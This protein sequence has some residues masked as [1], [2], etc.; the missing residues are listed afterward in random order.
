MT[1]HEL[2]EEKIAELHDKYGAGAFIGWANLTGKTKQ[3]QIGMTRAAYDLGK[4]ASTAHLGTGWTNDE[5]RAAIN[6]DNPGGFLLLGPKYLRVILGRLG[7]DHQPKPKLPTEPG[8]MIHDVVDSNGDTYRVMTRDGLDT[9][10][11]VD[12]N[13]EAG[14]ID[15]DQITSFGGVLDLDKVRAG[16]GD[17]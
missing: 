12:Q 1:E 15:E 6:P 8:S 2:T 7:I 3:R 9:W 11:G 5:L 14:G 17:E 10:H 4:Q 16:D 13:G